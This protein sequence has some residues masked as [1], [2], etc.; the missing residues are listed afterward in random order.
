MVSAS[1][2][3]LIVKLCCQS[4]PVSSTLQDFVHELSFCCLAAVPNAK[5]LQSQSALAANL[6]GK[7]F[8]GMQ[9][10]AC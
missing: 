8:K 5:V 1:A 3:V 4:A 2:T 10:N 9:P 6:L 7:L